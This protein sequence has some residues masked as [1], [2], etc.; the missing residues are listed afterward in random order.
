VAKLTA[1]KAVPS[2]C[3]QVSVISKLCNNTKCFPSLAKPIKSVYAHCYTLFTRSIKTSFYDSRVAKLTAAEA[4]PS[5]CLQ[6]SVISWLSGRF[7][8]FSRSDSTPKPQQFQSR[9][10]RNHRLIRYVASPR[11]QVKFKLNFFLLRFQFSLYNG[12]LYNNVTDA[13][14]DHNN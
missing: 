5:F 3:I 2:F 14:N 8:T 6:V 7:S 9:A 10:L 11:C 1:A 4:V 12:K 13:Y